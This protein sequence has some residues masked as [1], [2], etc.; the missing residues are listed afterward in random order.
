MLEAAKERDGLPDHGAPPSPWLVVVHE[1]LAHVPEEV[2]TTGG[3]VEQH[4]G[5]DAKVAGE[6]LRRCSHE[7]VERLLVPGD[8]AVGR[9]LA[10]VG[11]ALLRVVADLGER[12]LVL[13]DVV[14]CLHY[15]QPGGVEAGPACA[16][17][18]LVELAGTKVP[19]ARAVVLGK[20]GHHHRADG[21]VDAYP[22]GVCAADDLQKAGLGQLLHEPAVLRQHPGVVHADSVPHQPRQRLPEL[23][24]EPE[25]ADQL[26]YPVLLLARAQRC[27]RQGLCALG[28]PVL[29]GVHDVD[30]RLVRLE[31]LGELLV[32]RLER[33]RER[34]RHRA[35]DP[36]DLGRSPARLALEVGA[37]LRRVAQRRG[38]EQE[39]RA[40]HLQ[41][42]HLVGPPALGVGVV[43]ELVHDDEGDVGVGT[44]TQG[45]VGEH[46]RGAA[47][48]R[49]VAVDAGVAGRHADLVGAE[50]V[51]ECEEL[52][53]DQR[54]D[55]SGVDRTTA[56]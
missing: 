14:G 6:Q 31:E 41:Q 32:H 3:H 52:L 15:D 43:V 4:R 11:A 18:H 19:G 56:G 13:D 37:K 50:D 26:G 24:R 47:Q 20:A 33:P 12:P 49:G 39:L 46:L 21:D 55:R 40:G 9:G 23:R 30:R 27:A 44:V 7:A 51:A 34:Q 29:G 17:G 54:L 1:Q 42:R 25:A 22:E 16:T 28:G 5:S 53:A 38:H 10:S 48:D 35:L 36:S 8:E 45:R 2:A